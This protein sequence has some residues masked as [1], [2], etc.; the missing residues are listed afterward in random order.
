MIHLLTRCCDAQ[1]IVKETKTSGAPKADNLPQSTNHEHPSHH[2]LNKSFKADFAS[3]I[4]GNSSIRLAL[5][6]PSRQRKNKKT[7]DREVQTESSTCRLDSRKTAPP[8][9]IFPRRRGGGGAALCLRS[10]GIF[11]EFSPRFAHGCYNCC[12]V[13]RTRSCILIENY[14]EKATKWGF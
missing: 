10:L 8:L 6:D 2:E 4:H 12:K 14:V 13:N 5:G 1:K 11:R 7:T 9:R 3:N